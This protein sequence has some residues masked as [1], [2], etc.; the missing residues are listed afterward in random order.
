[1]SLTVA[2]N[3]AVSGLQAAQVGLRSVSDNIANVNTPGYV[4]TTVNQQPLVTVGSGAGVQ[5][6]GTKRVTDQF[7]E[8]ASQTASGDSSRWDAISQYMDVAQG[9]FGDPSSDNYFF[10]RIDTVTNGFAAAANDPSNTLLR[11]QATTNVQD[12]LS[13]AQRINDQLNQLGG[14]MDTRISADVSSANDL[15][16]QIDGLNS[17]ISRAKLLNQDSSGA[18]NLQ[19]QLVNQLTGII[20]V[21]VTQRQGGGVDI[22]SLEGVQLAGGGAAKL[23]YNSSSTTPGYISVAP[24]DGIGPSTAIQVNSGEVRGLMDL[25]N[26][27]LP[28]LTDQLGELVQQTVQ[29]LNDAHN[30]SSAVP[31]PATLTGRNTGLDLT[32]AASNFTGQT[33]IAIVDSSGVVQKTV[34]LDFDTNTLSVDGVAAGGFSPATLDSDLTTAFGGTATASFSNGALS[35][36]AAGSGNGV[37]IDEGTS[38]KAGRGFSAFFGLNDLVRSNS[39]GTYDTGMTLSDANGFTP[40]DTI[41]LRLSQPD[42]KPIRDVTVAVPAAGAMSDLV[43]A[44]NSNTSGVGLYGQFSLD[45]NGH[46]TFSGSQPTNA[47]LSVVQDT[48]QRG[49]PGGPSISELFGLG[50]GQRSTRAD[51]YEVDP[52]IAGDPSKLSFA[53]LDLS[54]ASGAPALRPGDATGALALAEIGDVSARFGAAGA[55]GATTMTVSSYAS[56]FAGAIGRDAAS[57]SSSKDAANAVKTEADNR[58]Q[59]AESVNLD[60]E[61]V[62]M[63]TYQQAFNASARMIQATKDLFDVLANLIN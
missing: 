11:N 10:S 57:A 26:T 32:T 59:S 48:T 35:I 43:N 17:E 13:D 37:A 6:L 51:Q 55:L 5:V 8:T 52:V 33:S 15:L 4:R 27:K 24:A 58:L 44:L 31:A 34:T 45:S 19:S 3:A 18:E 63:T 23:V 53:K 36:S 61:L 22:R 14:T 56:Q 49:G 40:G 20:G 41:T 28:Q 42:G 21:R 7:L 16:S 2:M 46:L 30:A 38:N 50:T 12:F 25:R 60:E 54:V 1:M 29:Q 39:T 47:S 62:N 9:L